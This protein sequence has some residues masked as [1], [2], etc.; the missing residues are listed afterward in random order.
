[1]KILC[2]FFLFSFHALHADFCA[3]KVLSEMTFEEKIG[4]LFIAA[5]YASP[6]QAA[7]E[8]PDYSMKDVEYLIQHYH[9]GGVL[10]KMRW[11]PSHQIKTVAHLQSISKYPLIISQDC[12][13]GL[14]MRLDDVQRFPKNG[15][16]GAVKKMSLIYALGKEIARQCRI[17]G[18][19]FNLSP[20][21]DVNSN[22]NNPVIGARSFG[23]DP[24][25]VADCGT[26][27]ML[28]LQDGGVLACAK[29]FPG[30]GDTS[31]DSH[32]CL[33]TVIHD[34]VRLLSCEI[35]PFQKL[36]ENGVKAVMTGHLCMPALEPQPN[37]PASLSAKIIKGLLQDELKFDGLV[38]TDDLVMGAIGKNFSPE[39]AVV[40][41]FL[42]GNDL[43]LS[44]L[45]L[46]RCIK[47]LFEA[48]KQGLFSLEDLDYRVLKILKAKEWITQQA[49]LDDT[50][51]FSP[52]GSKLN[53]EINQDL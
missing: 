43:L 14:S 3:G 32:E 8:I 46:P 21:V 17:V 27:M 11:Q 13:W 22:P 1:M 35:Y 52:T 26:A 53:Q 48:Y 28:G 23:S 10:L 36:I 38:V 34:R 40:K 24:K 19:N 50:D 20:V 15:T 51:L 4:Q 42:A 31:Q 47:A 37:L 49:P 39:D 18:V 25:V 29:H 45:H 30:H 44:T 7:S 2:L 6:E 9:V 41:A 33:P 16:L 5:V 12:E